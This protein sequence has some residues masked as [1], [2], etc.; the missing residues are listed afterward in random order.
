[1]SFN[2]LNHLSFAIGLLSGCAA[3][4]LGIFTLIITFEG[5]QTRGNVG[6]PPHPGAV[7]FLSLIFAYMLFVTISNVII[8]SSDYSEYK[9]VPTTTTT[10]A[11]K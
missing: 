7:L 8:S 2:A 3:L 6:T 11:Q 5:W 9:R 4:V 1:M 10:I